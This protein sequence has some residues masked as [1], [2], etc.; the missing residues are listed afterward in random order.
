MSIKRLFRHPK[1]RGGARVAAFLTTL[2]LVVTA[3]VLPSA[4][5]QA[6]ER[7]KRGGLRLLEQ[8]GPNLVG[9]PTLATINGQRMSL[10]SKTT[11]L[12]LDEVLQRFERH[13]QEHSGGLGQ[14]LG[15]LPQTLA[16][17]ALPEELRDPSR[18]LTSRQMRADGGAGQVACIARKNDAGGVRGLYQSALAFAAS[19][20]VG[21]V[22]DARYVV[23]RKN[24]A[25]GHTHVLAMWT[26]GSFDI[27]AMFPEQGDA[28]GSDPPSPVPRPPA[29]K[30][31]LS[32]E[33]T[34]HPYALR[35]YDS[36]RSHADVL[37]HYDRAMQAAGWARHALPD[38]DVKEAALD[39]KEH[40][41]AFAQHGS[42]LIVLVHQTAQEKT[43]V[44]LIE[45]GST[46]FVRTELRQEAP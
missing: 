36:E 5:A 22:G 35:M 28:P 13:C 23:A 11:P 34:G 6:E 45:M 27:P 10:G 25:N 17:A 20:N 41:A 18:W 44:T 21:D 31:V 14:E 37:S 1:L 3:S 24:P 19:G 40:V 29:A 2:N 26:E 30:R 39:L 33:I 4:A 46:G 16:G 38:G 32:A 8:L 15:R 43:G 9:E 12:G 42:A 7:V